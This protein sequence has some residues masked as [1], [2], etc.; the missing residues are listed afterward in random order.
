MYR[1]RYGQ[2]YYILHSA[3]SFMLCFYCIYTN[4]P[5]LTRIYYR[6]TQQSDEVGA[7]VK[8]VHFY[9]FFLVMCIFEKT[10]VIHC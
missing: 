9:S 10:S 6:D 7:M 5:H 1:K 2:S 3:F 4:L 8:T